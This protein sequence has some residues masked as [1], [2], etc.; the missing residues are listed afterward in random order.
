VAGLHN[1]AASRVKP[2]AGAGHQPGNCDRTECN[3]S[4]GD[5]G[6][7]GRERPPGQ[8]LGLRNVTPAAP[9][10]A[11]RRLEQAISIV[12]GRIGSIARQ[13]GLDYACPGGCVSDGLK[14]STKG[15]S[16]GNVSASTKAE[17]SALSWIGRALPKSS[18]PEPVSSV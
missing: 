16:S 13:A 7:V 4:V 9:R 12:W 17:R 3:F 10:R 11:P 5:D 15:M 1:D 8:G 14:R 6:H 2:C 18:A